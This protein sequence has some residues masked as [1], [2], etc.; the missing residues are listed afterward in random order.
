MLVGLKEIL[1]RAQAGGFAIPAFNVYNMETVMGVI[2]AAE[3]KK[4][5]VI[6]QVYNRLFTQGGARFLAPVVLEAAHS[7][8]VPVCF[9]IDHG[10]GKEEIVRAIRYGCSSVMIDASACD[11]EENIKSTCEI[12]TLASANNMDVEGELGHVGSVND[13]GTDE[14]TVPEEAKDFVDKTGIAALAVQVGTAHGRYKKPPRLDITR[15]EQISG[16]VN[17]PLVLHG[18]SGIPDDQIRASVKAGVRKIN[19]GTDL[20]YAFLDR[21][22]AVSRGI[23]ALDLFMKEPVAG[24]KAFAAG[25]IELLGADEKA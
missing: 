9:H 13:A 16:L 4:A 21:V 22:N 5:P 23:Y 7:T 14:F 8:C 20:C 19:F 11:Y 3:E 18:G 25:K 1:G 15:I 2:Q 17:I 12:V 6:C 10:A 24:V